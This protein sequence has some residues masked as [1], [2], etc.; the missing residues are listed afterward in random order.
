MLGVEDLFQFVRDKIAIYQKFSTERNIPVYIALG[1]GGE[2]SNPELL[3]NIPLS[4][5][6]GAITSRLKILNRFIKTSCI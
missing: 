1:V 6:H 5:N 2:P 4:E 3:Y